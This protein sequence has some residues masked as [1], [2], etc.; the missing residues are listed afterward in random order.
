MALG[1]VDAVQKRA[2]AGEGI[3]DLVIVG[4]DG[5][6]EA[7]AT[8]DAGGT[9]FRSTVVQESGRVAEVAVS[10]LLKLRAHEPV[11]VKTFIP[12]TIYPFG[13]ASSAI[14]GPGAAK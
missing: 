1:A 11:E 7:I 9:R 5:T 13:N 2:A 12:T 4:V 6:R 8:I 10:T 14:S 3:G